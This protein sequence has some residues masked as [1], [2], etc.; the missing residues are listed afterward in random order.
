MN[1][2][3]QQSGVEKTESR[4]G[5]WGLRGHPVTQTGCVALHCSE[6]GPAVASGDGVSWRKHFLTIVCKNVR[7]HEFDVFLVQQTHICV[8]TQRLHFNL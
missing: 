6:S 2:G 1:G 7:A 4:P 8:Y 5:D 3:Q